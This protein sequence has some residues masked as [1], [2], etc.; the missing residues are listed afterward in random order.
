[1]LK[2]IILIIA[3]WQGITWT[4][5]IVRRLYFAAQVK[6]ACAQRKL[7]LKW[8]RPILASLFV[9]RGKIDFTVDERICVAILTVPRQRV[10]CRLT[11]DT[12]ELIRL[13][14]RY[15]SST[16]KAVG[17]IMR[18]STLLHQVGRF[19][20]HLS[21]CDLPE[22]MARVVIFYPVPND[23]A[24]CRGSRARSVGRGDELAGGFQF[25]TRTHFFAGLEEYAATGDMSV[26]KARKPKE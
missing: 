5:L 19:P 23:V 24:D 3:V 14:Q 15:T 17:R 2:W 13:E 4:W 16:S 9:G 20:H 10:I 18:A 12:A 6:R 8:M 11:A 7:R 26:W 1:M 21:K 22:G 25:N